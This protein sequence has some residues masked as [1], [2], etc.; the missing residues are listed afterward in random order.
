VHAADG[1]SDDASPADGRVVLRAGRDGEPVTGNPH[2]DRLIAWIPENIVGLRERDPRLASDWR[3]ALRGTVGAALAGPFNAE[4][5][6][7]D[8]WL[9][10]AR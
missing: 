7:R 8:G 4:S 1:A 3:R 2:G 5:I 10:L 9:V 6:S